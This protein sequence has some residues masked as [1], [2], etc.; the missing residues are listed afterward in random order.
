MASFLTT[1]ICTVLGVVS[2]HDADQ[3]ALVVIGLA[4]VAQLVK[5]LVQVGTADGGTVQGQ[6]SGGVVDAGLTG[7]CSP[8]PGE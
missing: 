5:G 8:G 7:R 2:F 3:E 6:H 1:P 4:G